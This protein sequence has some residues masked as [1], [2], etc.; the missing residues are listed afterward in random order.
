MFCSNC[1]T[2]GQGKFCANCGAVVGVVAP[3]APVTPAPVAQAPVFNQPPVAPAAAPY[4]YDAPGGFAPVQPTTTSGMA[5]GA[6]VTSF[7]IPLIG[8]ILG[9]VARNEIKNSNGRKSGDGMANAAIILSSIFMVI[10][11]IVI[12]T[13]YSTAY[14]AYNY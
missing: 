10:Y 6:L 3:S 14:N 5:I 13:A 7:F 2:K 1:G 12:V 8:L 9:I 4:T 11:F